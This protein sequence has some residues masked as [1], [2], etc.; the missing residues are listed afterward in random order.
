[1]AGQNQSRWIR[2]EG[3]DTWEDRIGGSINSQHNLRGIFSKK[4]K[5][6]R[7]ESDFRELVSQK[8]KTGVSKS[9]SLIPAIIQGYNPTSNVL[10]DSNADESDGLQLEE[11][12]RRRSDIDMGL[13][14]HVSI[15]QDDG[16]QKD[17]H[18]H[19]SVIS[20]GDL[21]GLKNNVLVEL[22]MQAS[23]QQ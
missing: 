16:L 10:Y 13:L 18:K 20:G 11:R 1:M 4:G 17:Q 5:G 2:E 21:A 8:G 3:D 9:N 6:I 14:D 22:A 15:H 23:Q 12:K 19:G 7:E